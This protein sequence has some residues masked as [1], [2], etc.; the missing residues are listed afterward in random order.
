MVQLS[1]F[2]RDRA[3]S[4]AELLKIYDK[5]AEKVYAKSDRPVEYDHTVLTTWD[6]SL[7]KLSTEA[8]TLQNLLIFFDPDSLLERL[9]TNTKAE[10][11]DTELSFLLDEFE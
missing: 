11:E 2:I 8:R 4:Y 10:L 6:I 5:S 9:I 3:Y 1:D 7:Q